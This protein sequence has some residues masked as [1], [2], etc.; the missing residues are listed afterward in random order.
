MKNLCESP[1]NSPLSSLG[2]LL[3]FLSPHPPFIS[4]FHRE[5]SLPS[6]HPLSTLSAAAPAPLS[7]LRPSRRSDH[8]SLRSLLFSH[9]TISLFSLSLLPST[10]AIYLPLATPDAITFFSLHVRYLIYLDLIASPLR[11]QSREHEKDIKW[12]G[13]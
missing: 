1:K 6:F 10:F 2:S 4:H 8:Y 7:P 3:F 5:H 12:V 11:G 13:G 9:R